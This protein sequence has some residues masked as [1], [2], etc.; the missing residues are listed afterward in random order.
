M[1]DTNADV[2]PIPITV[3]QEHSEAVAPKTHDRR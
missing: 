1:V 2:L 3:F